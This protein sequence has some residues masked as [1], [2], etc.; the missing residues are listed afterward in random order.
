V[1]AAKYRHADKLAYSS[2]NTPANLLDGAKAPYLFFAA[3]VRQTK[4]LRLLRLRLNS[5]LSFNKTIVDTDIQQ[6]AFNPYVAIGGYIFYPPDALF[7]LWL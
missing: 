7:I 6:L 2:Y 4:F 5:S 1:K 3:T